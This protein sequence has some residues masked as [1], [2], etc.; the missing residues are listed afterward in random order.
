MD[1]T[2]YRGT[3]D[4]RKRGA[5]PR[6]RDVHSPVF[7]P[8]FSPALGPWETGKVVEGVWVSLLHLVNAGERVAR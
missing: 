1:G 8:V 4:S 2:Q 5:V 7:S 3:P 6:V